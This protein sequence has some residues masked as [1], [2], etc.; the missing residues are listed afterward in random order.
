VLPLPPAPP[1]SSGLNATAVNLHSE[2]ICARVLEEIGTDQVLS[3]RTNPSDD[4][5]YQLLETCM[6]PQGTVATFGVTTSVKGDVLQLAFAWYLMRSVLLNTPAG[7]PGPALSA[8][9]AAL[10]PR[11]FRMPERANDEH[12]VASAGLSCLDAA[13]SPAGPTDLHRLCEDGAVVP[14]PATR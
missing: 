13:V 8:S 14:G 12:L 7:K 10:S 4:P 6:T 5:I 3:S 11:D 9:L 1:A 2:P